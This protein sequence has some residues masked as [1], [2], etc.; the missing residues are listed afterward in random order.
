MVLERVVK[1]YYDDSIN[2]KYSLLS[3]Q[4]H[5][6]EPDP[7]SIILRPGRGI[8]IGINHIARILNMVG[9]E[10]QLVTALGRFIAFIHYGIK[11]DG[12][13]MEYLL[14]INPKTNRT[15]IYIV[16]FDRVTLYDTL[17]NENVIEMFAWSLG[18]EPYFPD[19]DAQ[20]ELYDVFSHEYL[21]IAKK[22]GYKNIAEKV[23]EEYIE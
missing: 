1:P 11:T 13:D 16:D 18:S 3:Y 9:D 6:G 4:A 12:Q 7:E 2:D 20:P 21:Q 15:N 23:L 19:P 22:F 14:G 17:D 5:I 8:Y 10:I